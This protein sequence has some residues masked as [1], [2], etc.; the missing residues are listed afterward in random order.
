VEVLASPAPHDLCDLYGRGRVAQ[1]RR[2]ISADLAHFANTRTRTERERRTTLPLPQRTGELS[3]VQ[4]FRDWL[5]YT[6][7]TR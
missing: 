1:A 6:A 2:A 4:T 5:W 3:V 7:G